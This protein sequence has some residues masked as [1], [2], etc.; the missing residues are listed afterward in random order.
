MN[1]LP[2]HLRDGHL[3]V[4]LAGQL[5]LIDTGAPT[6]FGAPG[7]ISIAGEE[8]SFDSSCLGLT[9]TTLTGFV[10]VPCVGLLGADV[11]GRFD[12][13]FDVAKGSL[14]ITTDE[15]PHSG[16]TVD[17]SYFM[18]IPIVTAQI[19]G[20]DYRMFFD[21]GAQISYFQGE[22]LSDFPSAGRVMDFYPGFGQFQTDTHEVAV[23]LAGVALT[24]RCGTLPGMLGATLMMA[25]T[26]GIVGN[27]ILHNRI[28]GYFPRRR[29]LVL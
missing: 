18:G 23:M 9:A 7:R 29:A 25:D 19:A 22:S 20:A 10:G 28:V 17:L 1:T 14:A 13:I 24:L 15:L 16:Q 8:F 27:Q 11:L 12:L 6:S 3:F 4:E 26:E 21:T 5:W 2:L